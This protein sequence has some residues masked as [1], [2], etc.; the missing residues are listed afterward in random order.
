LHELTENELSSPEDAVKFLGEKIMKL[1]S[2]FKLNHFSS[3]CTE[4]GKVILLVDGFDEIFSSYGDEVVGLVK[5]LLE[6]KIEKIFISTRPECCE[7]LEMEFVQIKHSLEPFSESDQKEYFTSFLKNNDKFKGFAE[8]ELEKIVEAFVESMKRSISAKDYKHTGVPL[9]TKLVAEYLVNKVDQANRT[10]L[11]ETVQNLKKEKFNLSGLYEKFISNS[12]HI[13]FKEKRQMDVKNAMNRKI[14]KKEEKNLM[15]NF[16]IFAIQQFLKMETKEHFPKFADRIFSDDEIEE[17]A[18]VGLIYKTEDGYKFVHQTF[19]EYLFTL[20]LMENFEQPK[21]AEFIVHFLFVEPKFE[22]IRAFVDSWIEG[23]MTLEFFDIY[24]VEFLSENSVKHTTPIHVSSKEQNLNTQN[25]IYKCLTKSSNFVIQKLNVERC[26]FKSDKTNI[27]AI[28]HLLKWPENL[29]LT[30]D[31]IKSD[32]GAEFFCDIFRHRIQIDNYNQNFLIYNSRHGENLPNILKWLRLNFTDSIFLKKQISSVDEI[33]NYGIIHF[34]FQSLPNQI[35]MDLVDEVKSWDEKL[36][37]DLMGQ[38]IL[39]ENEYNQFFLN[40]YAENENFDTDSLIG[41]LNRIKIYFRNDESFLCKIIF[42]TDGLQ[43]SFLNYFCFLAKNFDLLKF[44]KWLYNSFGLD[45]VEKLL[46]CRDDAKQDS[47]ILDYFSN[48]RHSISTGLEILK[49][50]EIDLNFDKTFLKNHI[51][52]QQNKYHENV[53]QLIFVRSENLDEF[54]SFTEDDFEISG[55][56]LKNTLIESRTFLFYFAQKSV[57]NQ[58][59]YL[60][61]M[62]SKFGGNIFQELISEET[63]FIIC[64]QGLRFDDF[65]TNVLT[66]FDFVVQIF[67]ID[68]LEKLICYK[69]NENNLTFLF[70]L[71]QIAGKCLIKI[72]KYLFEKFQNSKILENLLLAIDDYGNSFLIF[73]CLQPF[74]PGIIKNCK[75]FL[76]LVKN[77]F[78]LDFLKKFLLIKNNQNNNFHHVLMS[79]KFGG[80]LEK[81]L[82]VL[83]VLQ[84]VVGKDDRFFIELTEDPEI[85]DQIKEF[86]ETKL[87]ITI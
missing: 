75:E 14:I 41:I 79:N 45:N 16:Q 4:T 49:F 53:L 81:T 15:A 51:I 80:G 44:L 27:P 68:F 56:E 42:H 70:P 19:A 3:S 31:S 7:L 18:K 11:D 61:F 64:M 67:D 65:G 58:R 10:K 69:H 47:I 37:N 9:V 50:L 74:V 28:F 38:L 78:D 60:S 71:C 25:F 1:K 85:P 73:Y 6:T 57:E 43:K 23:M 30:L 34:A 24:F 20:Y 5:L 21:V 40:Y 63:L 26:L 17:M 35:L 62:E 83:E 39:M 48:D 29:P 32:F 55:S 12:F 36:G 82:D 77:N 2:D 72:L 84:E 8:K 76:E 86:L 46:V 22:V 52:L 13:Y 33:G 87:Q 66:F 54:N 59:K